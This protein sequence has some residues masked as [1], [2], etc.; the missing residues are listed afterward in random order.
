MQ[1]LFLLPI[2][3][4]LTNRIFLTDTYNKEDLGG[5]LVEY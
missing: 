5:S 2:T 3:A 1:P 4:L